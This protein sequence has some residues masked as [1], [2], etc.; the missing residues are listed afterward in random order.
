MHYSITRKQPNSHFCF[1]CGL[2]NDFGLKARFFETSSGELT[3]IFQP[4]NEHQG[5][6]GRLHGGLISTILDE[7]MARAI[8]VGAGEQFWGVTIDLHVKFA[9]PIPLDKECR[10]LGRVIADRR[11]FFETSGE[12]VLED[13]EIAASATGRYIKLSLQQIGE[14]DAGNLDWRVISE[15]SDPLELEW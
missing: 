14:I 15:E 7:V 11:R 13:G 12:I 10:V 1:A 9:K 5:Y 8:M 4:A 2:H 6:P 3:G